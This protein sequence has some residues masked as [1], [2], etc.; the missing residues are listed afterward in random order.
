MRLLVLTYEFPPL[1]GGA[2]NAAAQLVAALGDDPDVEVVVVTS[3]MGDFEVER[4]TLTP[5]S[6]IYRLPIG[7]S[8][9]NIHYQTNTDLLRY[10]W[11]CHRF[12]K[13]L[14]EQETFDLCHAHMTLP[15]GAIAWWFRKK[16]PYLVALQGSDVPNY[17]ERFK[18]HYTV[19]TP[20][21]HRVWKDA[22]HV[23]SNSEGLRE[24]ALA[25]APRQRI[26]VIPNGIRLELFSPHGDGVVP[27][28]KL[29]VV[30]VSR[31]IERKGVWE[32]VEGFRTVARRI[33]R[34]HLDLIG[35]GILYEQL[36]RRVEQQDLADRVT[37]HG[38]VDHEAVPQHLRRAS[39]FVL[40]SHAE[41]MSNA[42]LE[43][44]ACGLAVVVTDTGGTLEL[45]RDNGLIVPKR[46][47]QALADAMI[48]ILSDDEKRTRMARA[49]QQIARTFSWKA[50]ARQYKELY[51]WR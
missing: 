41:G 37:L 33:P 24:L 30:C 13:E 44:M 32:L 11:A 42:L 15:A 40:P 12:L 7:K 21:I 10:A 8:A 6:T 23:V 45:I 29:S 1:G 25:T 28:D 39:L 47:P 36:R 20:I 2:G 16:M 46:D 48:E 18:L 43:G 19:L 4:H 49:S 50:M 14:L 38:A 51:D 34:A 22:T 31:L 5:N 3:S 9:A 17:S 26:E 35:T 27:Q